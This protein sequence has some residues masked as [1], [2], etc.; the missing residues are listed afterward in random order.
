MN[1]THQ[2]DISKTPAI[3]VIITAYNYGRYIKDA[4]S[5][6][7]SQDFEDFELIIMNNASSD[8]TDEIVKT[9]L[10]D[11]RIRYFVND[12]NIGAV[13]NY[14]KG[15]SLS[16]AP[17]I[18]FLS[19]DDF[20][21]PD[22]L[23]TLYNAL[24]TRDAIDFVYAKYYFTGSDGKTRQEIN[25]RAWLP[26]EHTTRPFAFADLLMFDDYISMC[27]VLFRRSVFER[28]GG[29]KKSSITAGDYVFFCELIRDGYTYYFVD[30]RVTIFRIHDNQMSRG[31]YISN[32][33][34]AVDYIKILDLFFQKE[35]FPKLAGCESHIIALL[36]SKLLP[37]KNNPDT[38][39]EKIDTL[40]P[41]LKT[42]INNAKL[43]EHLKVD[44]YPIVS[45]ILTTRSAGNHFVRSLQ[46]VFSQTFPGI[47]IIVINRSTED[48][49]NKIIDLDIRRVTTVVTI[50]Q[51]K[52]M[53]AAQKAGLQK[54]QGKFIAFL[55]EGEVFYLDHI[56]LTANYLDTYP[57]IAAVFTDTNI[58]IKDNRSQQLVKTHISNKLNNND[59]N[60]RN[61]PIPVS[62]LYRKDCIESIGAFDKFPGNDSEWDMWN[63]ISERYSTSHIPITTTEIPVLSF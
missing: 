15:I 53:S 1:T 63:R 24:N 29:F 47:E 7:L 50:D 6:V 27:T 35:N 8:E 61:Y 51:T 43:C 4:I 20:I 52:S 22:C 38:F 12:S 5:S 44:S 46:S 42:I 21:L 55:N 30:K 58:L 2:T 41:Q 45:V 25:H 32:G 18:F 62:V 31:Q 13:P 49:E 17:Y 60:N 54:V 36:S 48:L 59:S 33:N 16:R 56:R 40:K 3:S 28:Y 39:A 14:N 9:F 10:D 57:E 23:S 26:Y 11:N 19:A 34:E 37:L